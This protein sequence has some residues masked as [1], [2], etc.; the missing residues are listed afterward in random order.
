MT[1][2]RP[3]RKMLRLARLLCGTLRILPLLHIPTHAHLAHQTLSLSTL[4]RIARTHLCSSDRPCSNSFSPKILYSVNKT[5]YPKDALALLTS[6]SRLKPCL[7]ETLFSP[8]LIGLLLPDCTVYLC[9]LTTGSSDWFLTI[10]QLRISNQFSSLSDRSD[11]LS[12]PFTSASFAF[13]SS[14]LRITADQVWPLPTLPEE[15][16]SPV[17]LISL[18][19]VDQPHQ[20]EAPSPETISSNFRPP[21]TP[22]RFPIRFSQSYIWLDRHKENL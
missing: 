1:A 22:P 2:M 9:L 13:L 16:N 17:H 20:G 10:W 11:L 8:F 14:L 21:S 12:T 18:V 15:T 6:L 7:R 19:L 3:S 4:L 5:R